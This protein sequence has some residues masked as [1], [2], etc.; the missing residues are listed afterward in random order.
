MENSH[1]LAVMVWDFSVCC[2][3]TAVAQKLEY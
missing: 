2:L 3:A 1:A